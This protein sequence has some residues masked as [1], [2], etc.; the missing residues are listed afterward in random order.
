MASHGT[1]GL[2]VLQNIVVKMDTTT[3]ANSNNGSIDEEDQEEPEVDVEAKVI[4]D[5]KVNQPENW[6]FNSSYSSLCTF[7]CSRMKAFFNQKRTYGG[8]SIYLKVEKVK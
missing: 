4:M 7:I 1:K 8:L 5:T 3:T 2:V 6:P